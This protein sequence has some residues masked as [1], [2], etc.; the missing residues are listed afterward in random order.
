[1]GEWIELA[2]LSSDSLDLR[3]L[4]LSDDGVDGT[5]VVGDVVLQPGGFVVLCADGRPAY[6]GGVQ[7]DGSY[8]YVSTGDGLALSNSQDELIVTSAS[9]QRLDRVSYSDGF[10]PVGRSMGLRTDRMSPDQNDN[11]GAWCAQSGSM[12]DGDQGTPGQTNSGC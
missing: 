12:P 3:D 5:S 7:C 10:V 8:V 9:G 6:N 2:S 4:V 11:A 1:M